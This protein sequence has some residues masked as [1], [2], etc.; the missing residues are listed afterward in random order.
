VQELE[1]EKNN[2]RRSAEEVMR[3][4]KEYKATELDEAK[5]AFEKK[6]K[7]LHQRIAVAVFAV[8]ILCYSLIELV[9][10]LEEALDTDGVTH[11]TTVSSLR[12]LYNEETELQRQNYETIMEQHMRKIIAIEES[13]NELL[14]NEREQ[15]EQ[16]FLA[17]R[18]SFAETENSWKAHCHTLE[19]VIETVSAFP[20]SSC[21]TYL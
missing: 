16:N 18:D 7:A 15:H 3:E 11:E 1:T 2:V 8:H 19:N 14:R 5:E 12:S 4:F 21:Q 10:K 17:V 13:N 6:Q 9:Q 20:S